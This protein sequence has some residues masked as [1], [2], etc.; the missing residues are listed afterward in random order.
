MVALDPARA[1]VARAVAGAREKRLTN[2]QGVI[3]AAE[4]LPIRD[5]AFHV[6]TCR[7]AAHHFRDVPAALREMHRVLRPGGRLAISDQAAADD[8][9][10]RALQ[11]E[12]EVLH[13][14]THVRTWTRREW[15]DACEAAGFR[16]V[17]VTGGVEERL[18]ELPDGTNI[19]EWCHRSRTPPEAEA[20]IRSLLADAPASCRETLD[21]QGD[22]P[23]LT[24]A[25]YKLVVA[26]R[27]RG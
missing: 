24:F 11:H 7:T 13:D 6:V 18:M 16:D 27:R 21:V 10:L 12:L 5:G 1:M 14:A 9:A 23:S 25:I 4:R 19:A 15:Q 17:S 26:A 3:A 20:R 2:V 22:G 8:G